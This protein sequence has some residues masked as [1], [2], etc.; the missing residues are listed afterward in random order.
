MY[1][2]RH[3]TERAGQP[4]FIMASTGEQVTYAELEA[5]SNRL[6]HLLS[7][8]GLQRLDHYSIFMENNNRYLEACTAGERAGLYYTCVNSYLMP[9]ELAFILNNSQSKALITSKA[10]HAVAAKALPQCPH[11]KLLLIVDGGDEHAPF[12][13]LDRAV[14]KFPGTPIADEWLGTPM[15]YS[16]GTTG[17]PKGIL[18]PLPENPPAK[19]LPIFEFLSR[20]WRYREGMI[21]LS[22]EEY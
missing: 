7:A 12:V 1:P 20:L 2:G 15:L 10:N 21:Y 14:E 4:A 16:S 9:D 22:P 6:A 19:P 17:R 11:V 8:R 18:R 13:N 5:R 3:V